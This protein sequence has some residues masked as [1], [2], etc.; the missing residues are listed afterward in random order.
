ME[1]YKE[2]KRTYNT[3]HGHIVWEVS[4]IGNVLKNGKKYQ[5]R[6]IN[7]GYQV[8]SSNTLDILCW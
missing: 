6:V 4:N 5:T 7:S 2:Y 8:L 1:V 3:R